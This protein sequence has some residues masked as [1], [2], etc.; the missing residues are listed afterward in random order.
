MSTERKK[1]IETLQ[2]NLMSLTLQLKERDELLSEATERLR[3]LEK[4]QEVMMSSRDKQKE[5]QKLKGKC[6]WYYYILI[7]CE[8][9]KHAI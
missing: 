7:E 4:V 1:E 3:D 9:S 5:R 2:D 8:R 6:N